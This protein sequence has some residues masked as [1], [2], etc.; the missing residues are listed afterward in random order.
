MAHGWVGWLQHPAEAIQGDK[1]FLKRKKVPNQGD[2]KDPHIEKGPQCNGDGDDKILIF[3]A[4]VQR[5]WST[6]AALT[7]VFPDLLR[8]L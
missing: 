1:K 3:P 8:C 4:W 5:M 2:K 6:M 7:K